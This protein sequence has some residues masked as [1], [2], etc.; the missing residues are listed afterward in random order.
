MGLLAT[1]SIF[2]ISAGNMLK[3]LGLHTLTQR[4]L[5]LPMD[6]LF[7]TRL[8]KPFLPYLFFTPV[9]CYMSVQ[10]KDQDFR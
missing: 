5:I 4:F 1:C 8:I 10:V 9:N 3:S 2:L 6:P 7:I